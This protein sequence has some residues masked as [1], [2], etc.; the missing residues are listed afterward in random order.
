MKKIGLFFFSLFLIV[1]P[2]FGQ[3][4]EI[5]NLIIDQ[6]VTHIGHRFHEE[7]AACWE[8]PSGFEDYNIFISEETA[9]Q[10]GSWIQIEAGGL[11]DKTIVYRRQKPKIGEIEEE[12]KIG[13]D[14]VRSFLA[15][16]GNEKNEFDGI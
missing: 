12:I 1:L 8:W 7:F 15:L 14:A 4:I 16:Q 13:I 11:I 2:V 3:D 10:Y 6:T 5:G 9:A